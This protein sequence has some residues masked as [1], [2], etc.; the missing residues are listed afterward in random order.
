MNKNEDLMITS[1]LDKTIKFWNKNNS[2]WNV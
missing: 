1:S 2:K